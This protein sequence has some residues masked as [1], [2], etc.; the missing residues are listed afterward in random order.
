MKKSILTDIQSNEARLLLYA[1]DELSLADRAQVDQM[2]AQ[3]AQLRSLLAQLQRLDAQARVRLDA[4]S[5]ELPDVDRAVL[6]AQRAMREATASP[7]PS[8]APAAEPM[9]LP[10]PWWMYPVAAA[11][12]ILVAAAMFVANRTPQPLAPPLPTQI[13]SL[14]AIHSQV[15]V[16]SPMPSPEADRMAE[17]LAAS[18][19]DSE[20]VLAGAKSSQ[21]MA[22]ARELDEIRASSRA[23]G[24]MSMQ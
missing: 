6:K 24:E 13:A 22:A 17:D 15:D 11:A 23:F 18:F 4:Q 14:D 12:A 20:H 9:K 1:A 5:F 2:L 19:D 3:D 7:A 8:T 10:L 16:D 21:L